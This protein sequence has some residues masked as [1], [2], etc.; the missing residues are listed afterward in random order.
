MKNVKKEA[1]LPAALVLVLFVGLFVL[2]RVVPASS[3]LFVVLKKGAIY[4]LDR[5][6]VV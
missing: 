4:A 1:I 5:K 3:I 2:E 6:S